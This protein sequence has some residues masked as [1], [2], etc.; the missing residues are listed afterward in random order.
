MCQDLSVS[1]IDIYNLSPRSS[2]KQISLVVDVLLCENS[3]M[4]IQA[5]LSSTSLALSH[6]FISP[7]VLFS[8]IYTQKVVIFSFQN[9]LKFYIPKG[10]AVGL[11]HLLQQ[12]RLKEGI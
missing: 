4:D 2:C 9:C 5:P 11:A 1:L 3:S 8:S 6:P 12:K 10:L 7:R